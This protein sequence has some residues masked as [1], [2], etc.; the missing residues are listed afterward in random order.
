MKKWI[1]L[2]LI[3][4][5]SSCLSLFAQVPAKEMEKNIRQIYK[6]LLKETDKD[7][8]DKISK[9]EYLAIYQDKKSAEENFTKWDTSKDDFITEDEYVKSIL[10]MGKKK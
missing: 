9:T 6:D 8:D 5:L 2:V 3:I 4:A 1:F 7:K 10:D